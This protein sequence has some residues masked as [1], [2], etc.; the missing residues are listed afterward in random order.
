MELDLALAASFLVLVEERNYGR[1]AARLHLTSSALTKRIQR[2]E[3][4]L[5]VTVVERGPAGVLQVTTAGRR[6]ADAAGPLLAHARTARAIARSRP[7]NY[8][9]RI[10]LPAGTGD[11]LPR[12]RLERIV[13]RLHLA[14]PE[15]SFTCREVPFTAM[16]SCLPDGWVDVLWTCAPVRRAGVECTPIP[17]SSDLVGVVGNH[18]PL[19]DAGSI[20]AQSF[21]D[22]QMLYNPAIADDWMAPFWLAGIRPR[23]QARLVAADIANQQTALRM[24]AEGGAVMTTLAFAAPLLPPGLRPVSLIGAPRLGFYTAR[25]DN[26]RRDGVLAMIE[27]FRKVAP[28]AFATASTGGGS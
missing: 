13:R 16:D 20:E 14:F 11:F 18:H 1:A 17:V 25:R 6:F 23:S 2:L 19:A 5:G 10:G 27:E 15:V 7:R 24:A 4:Q 8:V 3:R 22:E 21:C 28:D 26:D 9:V 12:I